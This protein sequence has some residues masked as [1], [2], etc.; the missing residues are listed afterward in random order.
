MIVTTEEAPD[1][2]RLVGT[3]QIQIEDV[4]GDALAG[5]TATSWPLGWEATSDEAGL[6]ILSDLPVGSYRV[7]V[8]AA[9]FG[10]TVVESIPI[11]VGTTTEAT[12]ALEASPDDSG[13]RLRVLS[14]LASGAPLV[15][16]LVELDDGS[17][18]LQTDDDGVAEFD[19]V[20]A[21][22]HTVL[23]TPPLD[24]PA[25]ARSA[26]GLQ[27]AADT[28]TEI[29][30]THSGVPPLDAT[31]L[32]SAACDGCHPAEAL[33]HGRSAHSSTWSAA[34]APALDA[35]IASSE[36]FDLMAADGTVVT[37]GLARDPAGDHV[38]LTTPVATAQWDVLGW[39]G[40][41]STAQVAM[42]N[43]SGNSTPGPFAWRIA[44]AGQL[45]PPAFEAGPVAFELD[46]WVGAAGALVEHAA[47]GGP[48]PEHL[49]SVAC[50]GCHATGLWLSE[51]DGGVVAATAITSGVGMAEERAVGCEACHGP[52]SSHAQEDLDDRANL[53]VNP[54]RLDRAAA[55]QVC[56]QCHSRGEA[57][58]SLPGPVRYPYT[59]AGPH[60][61]GADLDDSLSPTPE[62]WPGGASAA[63]NQQSTDFAASVH[64]DNDTYRLSCWDCHDS[65]GPAAED[66]GGPPPP[67]QLLADPDDNGLCLS[68]HETLHFPDAQAAEDH[69]DHNDYDPSTRY[70]S[71]R[72]TG[73][74]M[75]RTASR[76]GFSAFSGAG[77][78]ASHRSTHIK[79]D[80]TL[81]A[82]DAAGADVLPV[83][84][85]VPP[86]CLACH[87]WVDFL[88]AE[89][90]GSFG[91]PHGD[92]TLRET[93]D[94]LKLDFDDKFPGAP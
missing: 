3:L 77:E 76:F 29:V 91:G 93:Y 46:S 28:T 94:E 2:E 26:E 37:V 21:G 65:H 85:F 68:C 49:E 75:P 62:L 79:P 53:V 84:S 70:A 55:A 83:G 63:P 61:V 24:S 59:D 88:V 74:H 57:T 30:L 11:S 10:S 72:C 52:G 90:G 27:V 43:V 48:S 6:A 44:A 12:V 47:T 19:G 20:A 64:A 22:T 40:G 81:E 7:T 58:A 69:T 71:G 50:L 33:R 89:I 82:F 17:T 13:T 67:R 23:I 14:Q 45:A 73:C 34:P 15:G 42:L 8:A 56:A 92:P 86:S 9:G 38:S 78:L 1:P 16:A 54:A 66:P 87:R 5:A 36:E 80:E 51:G 35:A 4:E 25:L 41:A 18:S 31:W 60:R 39:Y 32:G